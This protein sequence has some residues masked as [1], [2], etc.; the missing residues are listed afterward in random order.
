M[1]RSAGFSLLELLIALAI[2]AF[3]AVVL[4]QSLGTGVRVW[5][6]TEDRLGLLEE[7][8][9]RREARRFI[10]HMSPNGRL[11]GPSQA[12]QG[13]ERQ[14]QF[15][16]DFRPMSLSGT[17]PIA[18][19]L[20]I[21]S[22]HFHVSLHEIGASD[23]LATRVFPDVGA[24]AFSYHD[25]GDEGWRSEWA[26]PNRRPLLVRVEWQDGAQ[27]TFVVRPLY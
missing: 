19:S 21:E 23:T 11:S 10:E 7:V 1:R 27:P 24:A 13:D 8:D 5:E 15:L 14:L 20:R 22:G 6:R 4:A 25:G 17:G 9:M 3:I 16:S 26:D 2:L 12:V 18:V